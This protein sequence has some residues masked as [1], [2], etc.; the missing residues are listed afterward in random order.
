MDKDA[1]D[2]LPI[3]P[4]RCVG[5]PRGVKRDE[6]VRLLRLGHSWQ[7]LISQGIPRHTVYEARVELR[8]RGKRDTSVEG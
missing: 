4:K 1:V 6:A 3:P 5:R 7:S 2:T 8:R